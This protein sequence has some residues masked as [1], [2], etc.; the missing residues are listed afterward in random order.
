MTE[1]GRGERA[2]KAW[3]Y[4]ALIVTAAFLGLL[5]GLLIKEDEPKICGGDCPKTPQ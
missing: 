3:T 2:V 4:V 5:T 1:D